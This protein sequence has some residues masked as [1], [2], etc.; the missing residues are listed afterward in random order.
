MLLVSEIKKSH[1]RPGVCCRVWE[2]SKYQSWCGHD[3]FKRH[4]WSMGDTCDGVLLLGF[5]E[6]SI[7]SDLLRNNKDPFPRQLLI[8]E[9]RTQATAKLAC[10][11]FSEWGLCSP[12]PWFR[13][14]WFPSRLPSVWPSTPVPNTA[15]SRKPHLLPP[16]PR[17]CAPQLL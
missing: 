8:N 17:N 3:I 6:S 9:P 16:S 13:V 11:M 4:P 1:S 14:T 2:L 15:S 10:S 5:A 7:V 12:P